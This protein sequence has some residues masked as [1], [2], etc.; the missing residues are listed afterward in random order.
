MQSKFIKLTTE[1][2]DDHHINPIFIVEVKKTKSLSES[3]PDTATIVMVNGDRIRPKE[4]V[5]QIMKKI[6]EATSLTFTL[7]K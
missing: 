1:C 5:E 2:G 4:T 6:K 3:Q 7:D